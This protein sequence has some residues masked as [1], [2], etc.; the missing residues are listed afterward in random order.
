MSGSMNDVT[1]KTLLTLVASLAQEENLLSEIL[2]EEDELE[3]LQAP[4]K[5]SRHIYEIPYYQKSVWWTLLQKGDCLL[6]ANIW[7]S[8]GVLE[9]LS[10][11]SKL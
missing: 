2:L 5:K 7:C 3:D 10:I 6:T 9:F 11:C 8:E 1:R 4:K